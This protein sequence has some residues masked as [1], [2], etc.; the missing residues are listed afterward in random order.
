VIPARVRKPRDKSKVENAVLQVER[1]VLA[2]LRNDRFFGLAE[3]NRAIAERLAWLNDR[4][5]SKLDGTRRSLFEQLDKPVLGPLPS[6]RF[7]IPEWRAGVGVN[8]DYHVEFDGHYYSVP[9]TLV[10]KKVDVR[11]TASTVECLYRGDRVAS[12]PR[13]Y[14]RGR[15]TS[16]DAH[17]PQAH[18]QFAAWT[19]QRII[20][21]AST[22]GPETANA[23]ERVM[24]NRKHPE[25][26]FRAALGIIRLGGRFGNERV[27]R[28]CERARQLES[29]SYRTIYSMLKTGFDQQPLPIPTPVSAVEEH[30]NVR[31]PEYYN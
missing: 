17:R 9:Y 11:G 14:V 31:G 24:Q 16:I 22:V 12:H 13:S 27:E 1:W 26:G 8:I 29:L 18:R 21:W 4:A 20:R 30:E 5:L 6:K 28:A 15:H 2:P 7:E 3:A 10:N 19:P 25:L 23:V